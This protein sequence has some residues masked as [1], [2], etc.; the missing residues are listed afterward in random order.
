MKRDG[1]N[2]REFYQGKVRFAIVKS[3][4]ENSLSLLLILLSHFV[5]ANDPIKNKGDLA[6]SFDFNNSLHSEPFNR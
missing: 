2:L 5:L 6:E 3:W 4:F 1:Y